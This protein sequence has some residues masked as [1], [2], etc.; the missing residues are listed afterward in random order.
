[1]KCDLA[2]EGHGVGASRR[3]REIKIAEDQAAEPVQVRQESDQE[4]LEAHLSMPAVARF[5]AAPAHQMG[6]LAFDQWSEVEQELGR[7]SRWRAGHAAAVP[8]RRRR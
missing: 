2:K 3:A 6:E 1:M 8:R 4:E 7:R 5:A